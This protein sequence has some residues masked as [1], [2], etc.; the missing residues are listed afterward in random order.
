ML[1]SPPKDPHLPASSP[2]YD[3]CYASRSFAADP[4]SVARVGVRPL[5][6]GRRMRHSPGCGSRAC[7]RSQVRTRP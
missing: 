4:N 5:G 3:N 6:Q 7:E 1:W 2:T